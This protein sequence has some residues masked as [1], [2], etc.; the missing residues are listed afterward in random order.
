MDVVTRENNKSLHLHMSSSCYRPILARANYSVCMHLSVC[1][2][3]SLSVCRGMSNIKDK[4]RF[5]PVCFYKNFFINNSVEYF[6]QEDHDV[7]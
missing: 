6:E 4:K 7:V 2:S 5:K 3:V 1:L